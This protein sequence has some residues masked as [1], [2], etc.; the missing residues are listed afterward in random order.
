MTT[1]HIELGNDVFAELEDP[2]S[3]LDHMLPWQPISY[4]DF[5]GA[6]LNLETDFSI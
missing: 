6:A 4:M 3:S 2:I 5:G 1:G